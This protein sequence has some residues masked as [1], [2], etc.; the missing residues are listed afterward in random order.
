MSDGVM[1]AYLPVNSEW[2][3]QPLPHMTLVYCGTIGDLS[4]TAKNRL[5]KDAISAGMMTGPI[6]LEV[7]GVDTFGDS[8]ERV[9][10]ITLFST[11]RLLTARKMVENWN[12]SE[13]P[14]NPHAT[15]GPE[16]TASEVVIP[17]MVYFDRIMVGWGDER[18]VFNLSR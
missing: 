5:A 7:T 9:D 18:M 15:I 11:P 8:F 3:R 6:G 13:H 10:V 1:I 17:P 14:F 4:P 12:A 2:A 16:G